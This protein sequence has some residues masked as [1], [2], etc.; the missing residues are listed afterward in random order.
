MVDPA[1]LLAFCVAALVV[2]IIPGPGVAY[3]TAQAITSG[4]RGGVVSA[5]GLSVGVLAHVA[6]AAV[7]LSALLLLSAKAMTIVKFA[8]AAYLIYLGWTMLQSGAS[9]LATREAPHKAHGRLFVDGV[10]VSVL[11]PKIA[12]FFLAFLPQFI[13]PV[14][15]S[16]QLQIVILGL[17][18]CGLAFVTDSLYALAAHA[19]S[20][21]VV[22]SAIRGFPFSK[23][24]GWMMIGLG[25]KAAFTDLRK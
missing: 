7:G 1:T 17:I 16:P 4:W 22:A 3:V 23:I 19:V 10:A 9:D 6:A 12:V 15:G 24:G 8:G 2:L 14:A 11:N 5:A 25:V 20:K 13:D 18:Y 21:R